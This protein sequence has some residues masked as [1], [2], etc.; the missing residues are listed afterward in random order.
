MGEMIQKYPE[1]KVYG[2]KYEDVITS[3][4]LHLQSNP[5]VETLLKDGDTI[6]LEDL[7]FKAISVPFHS[8]DSFIYEFREKNDI[9]FMFMGDTICL[10]GVGYV[11]EDQI[12][13]LYSFIYDVLMNYP[14]ETCFFTGHENAQQ[15]LKFALSLDPKNEQLKLL[16]WGV[17]HTLL[18]SKN[19]PSTP[20]CLHDEMLVNPFF[21]V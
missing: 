1:A 5:E 3:V 17:R 6:E 15:T 14:E 21:R 8:P 12:D 7:S 9:P 16:Q 4:I 19:K 2:G 20:T 10:G 11:L 18:K 13:T